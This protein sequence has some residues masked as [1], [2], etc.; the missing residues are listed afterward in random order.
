[1]WPSEA[2]PA[3]RPAAEE[4]KNEPR[5]DLPPAPPHVPTEPVAILKSGVVDGM[6]Y[7]LYVDGSIEA[8]LPSGIVRFA[9]ITELREHLAKSA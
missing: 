1:M 6:A 7:T 8:E 5:T 4:Q 3:K 9:S 2:P